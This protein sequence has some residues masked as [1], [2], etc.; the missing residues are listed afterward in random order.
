MSRS[1]A[2]R[3]APCR[4][5]APPPRRARAAPTS[6]AC[7]VT[8]SDGGSLAAST[9][10]PRSVRG[11]C[12]GRAAPQCRLVDDPL[13]LDCGE[14]GRARQHADELGFPALQRPEPQQRV[15]RDAASGRAPRRC[16]SPP[17]ARRPRRSRRSTCS[18][19]P[20]ARG[21][22]AAAR[23]RPRPHELDVSR[24]DRVKALDVPHQGA[25]ERRHPAPPQD[26]VE[27]DVGERVERRAADVGA[28][29]AWPSVISSASPS[30]SRS[31][32]SGAPV[33][34]GSAW[35]ARQISRR[36]PG[37]RRIRPSPPRPTRPGRS[38]GRDPG[39]TAR[40]LWRPSAA[41]VERRC[42]SPRRRRRGPAPGRPVPVGS[43]RAV[44]PRPSPRR[45]SAASN[46]P[47]W[48][49]AWAAAS[50]RSPRRAGSSVSATARWR[51]AAA[52]ASPPRACARSG[53]TL[54]LL[55]DIARSAPVCRGRGATPPV[56]S[57]SGSVA[58][59]RARCTRWRSSI[60]AER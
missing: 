41:A 43:R 53:R 45:P 38:R 58:S 32:G 8:V 42:R 48:R 47:A 14:L 5:C 28:A 12:T 3:P 50:A 60:D 1:S 59:A 46:A 40:A 37:P 6:P 24:R 13:P 39:R 10:P 26:V 57:V 44:R 7:R 31:S 55:G 49:L 36:M 56:G 35:T 27:R 16:R 51:N 18:R 21:G 15:R 4:H 2:S 9:P 30:S 17:P 25:G 54:E 20:T 34:G 52:A 22:A 23:P 19:G 33:G 11:R 29:A